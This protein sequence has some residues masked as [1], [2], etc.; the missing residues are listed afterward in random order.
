MLLTDRFLKFYVGSKTKS[1]ENDIIHNPNLE[2]RTKKRTDYCNNIILSVIP[3]AALIVFNWRNLS[4]EDRVTQVVWEMKRCAWEAAVSEQTFDK[5][6][7]HLTLAWKDLEEHNAL[8]CLFMFASEQSRLPPRDIASISCWL[9]ATTAPASSYQGLVGG[10][11][12]GR[13]A[14]FSWCRA[15]TLHSAGAQPCNM[16]ASSRSPDTFLW[17]KV[18]A[19]I[20]LFKVRLFD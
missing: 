7:Q 14:R 3:H 1:E 4:L 20:S 18:C 6:Q 11:G 12:R 15:D 16:T 19:I 8:C 5:S 2:C 10:G 13:G 9:N 17:G